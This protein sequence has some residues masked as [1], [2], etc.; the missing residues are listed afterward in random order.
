[1]ILFF[2]NVQIIREKM[3]KNN[4]SISA[5]VIW[6]PKITDLKEELHQADYYMY[7]EKK[8]INFYERTF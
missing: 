5:G 4:V 1:M 8:A 3:Q 2:S 7:Q 6:K